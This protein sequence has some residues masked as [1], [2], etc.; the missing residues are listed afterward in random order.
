MLVAVTVAPGM[1]V[2]ETPSN[3]TVAELK[4]VPLM[5]IVVSTLGLVGL[6]PAKVGT[7][8]KVGGFGSVP[9]PLLTVR[10]PVTAPEGI[11]TFI[12]V[13]V[14]L[15]DCTGAFTGPAVP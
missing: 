15:I 8:K 13:P 11:C 1:D 4:L 9:K 6:P 14:P 12:T 3:F 7:K 2:T 10:D 5:M